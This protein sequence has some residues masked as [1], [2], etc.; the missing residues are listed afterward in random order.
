MKKK[1]IG[2]PRAFLYYRYKELWKNYFQLLG[3]KIVISPKTTKTTLEIGKKYSIDEACLSSKIYIGH[4]YELK[5]KCDYILIPRI[6]DY[7]D[8][9]K[10]CVKFNAI[11]DIINN[12]FPELNIINYNIENTKKSKESIALIKL[13]IKLTKRP[14]KTIICFLKAK[15]KEKKYRLNEINHQKQVLL[16]KKKKILIISHPYNT[17]DNYIGK[18]ITQLL[19]NQ[20]IEIIYSDKLERKIS[21]KYAKKLSPTLYWTYSKEAI[22]SILY[23]KDYIEGII[24]LTSFPCG[25]DS[26]VNELMIRKIT[27]I[28]TLNILIDELTSSTGLETRIESFIDIIKERCGN[29]G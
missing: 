17:Y 11:Y 18:P 5:D 1:K 3:Y 12:I 2:I 13:G 24:F 15:Q 27:T 22:G 25:P 4:V 29:N 19:K 8:N 7:G 23:Y 16:N 6:S 14:L 10:V 28:P 9:E 20:N 26:L 21:K